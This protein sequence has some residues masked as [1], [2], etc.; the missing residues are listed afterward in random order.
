[1]ELRRNESRRPTSEESPVSDEQD[2]ATVDRDRGQVFHLNPDA[3]MDNDRH[4]AAY[5]G[6]TANLERDS[7][8]CKVNNAVNYQL[9][10]TRGRLLYFVIFSTSAILILFQITIPEVDQEKS[11]TDCKGTLAELFELYPEHESFWKAVN[12]SYKMCNFTEQPGVTLVLYNG[13][14]KVADCIVNRTAASLSRCIDA[15]KSPEFSYVDG[16]NVLQVHEKNSFLTKIME[17]KKN[18]GVFVF[19]NLEEMDLDLVKS[20]HFIC[21][22]DPNIKDNSVII[23]L[24]KVQVQNFRDQDLNDLAHIK[25]GQLWE[26]KLNERFPPLL[27]RITNNLAYIDENIATKCP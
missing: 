9:Q 26:E 13:D 20:L 25:L 22:S 12:V 27:G 7:Q 4:E 8:S 10:P 2:S 15:S 24:L 6:A 23:L 19:Q 18:L 14:G 5:E 21:D 1:M 11:L 16:K 17:L 3:E